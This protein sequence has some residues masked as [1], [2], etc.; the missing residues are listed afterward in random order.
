[1]KKV[2]WALVL[3]GALAVVAAGTAAGAPGNKIGTVDLDQVF[4][5]HPKTAAATADFN[6]REEEA[7][8]ELKKLSEKQHAM[9]EELEAARD[10]AK[11][12]LLSEE[13]RKEKRQ[14]AEQKETEYQ[15]FILSTRRQQ[16]SKLRALREEVLDMRKQ[17]VDE[18]QAELAEF[19]EAEGY[20]LILDKSGLTA[21]GLSVIAFSRDALDVTAKFI[22]YIQADKPAAPAGAVPAGE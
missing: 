20:A 17:I 9:E 2:M 10:A 18:M 12:P 13:T 21:N 16:E 11:S 3:A 14:L 8:A 5:A 1:M 4:E 6:Q 19:A 22:E 7:K 15:A